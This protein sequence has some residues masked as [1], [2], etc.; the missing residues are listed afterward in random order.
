[1][2]CKVSKQRVARLNNEI[3]YEDKKNY[4]LWIVFG[5]LLSTIN[6]PIE[7]NV[8]IDETIERETVTK[9]LIYEHKS[10]FTQAGWIDLHVLKMD[11]TEEQVALDILQSTQAFGQKETLQS[12]GY[13]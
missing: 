8:L 10:K 1:M 4:K 11:L 12:I 5:V 6:V 9:G 7:A 2:I 13:E 3:K